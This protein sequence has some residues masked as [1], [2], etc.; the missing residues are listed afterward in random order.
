MTVERM[1]IA[2]I[3][4]LIALAGCQSDRLANSSPSA[5]DFSQN[6]Q[7]SPV[8]QVAL[9]SPD[10][11]LEIVVST[12]DGQP[13]YAVKKDDVE[14]VSPSKLG[15]RFATGADLDA[16]F[17]IASITAQT[18]VDET[19]EQ[20]W[21][22]KRLVH[23]R[24][25]E[26]AIDFRSTENPD[27]RFLLRVRAFDDGF[28][29]RYEVPDTGERA[30]IDEITE[31][32]I[33]PEA[34]AWWTPAGEFNRYEYIYRTTTVRA[35][36]R[37]HTPF[38]VRLPDS[39]THLAIHEA[40]LVD[41]AG[42]WLDQRR[43]GVLEADLAPR[44]DGVKVRVEGAFKSPWRAVQVSDSAAGLINGSDIYLNLNKPNALGDVSYFKPGKYI[45]IWWGMHI[46][47]F[48]WGSGPKHGAT[49]KRTK[50]YIDFAAEHGFGGVLV[51][52]WNLGW[53]GDWFHNGEVFNFTTPYPDFDL[54]AL[55]DYAA[56]K[57]VEIIGHHETSGNISNYENQLE[58]AF[59]LYADNG[60]STVKTG[61]VA[62][63]SDLKFYDEDGHARYTWHA[64]QERVAHDLHV[65][66]RAHEYGIAINAHEPVKDTG[67]RRTYPNAVSREGARGMEFNA[68]G[69]PPNPPEHQAILPFT[70]LLAGPFD[71]T[72]GVFDLTPNG[73]D[74]ENR[75]PTT[76]AKQL[77][78]YV[79]I[80]SPV[81]MAADLP[82]NYEKHP[83]AFQFIKDVPADWEHSIALDGEVGDFVVMARQRRGG[84]DWYVGALTDENARTISIP[85]SFLEEGRQYRAEI[86][87]DGI[88]ADWR[89]AP[90]EMI[91]E[92]LEASSQD[93]LSFP[94]ATSGG[95]AVRL[96]PINT[97]ETP[98]EPTKKAMPS[99]GVLLKYGDLS[100]EF[101]GPRDVK[102]WLPPGYNESDARYRVIYMHDG[103]NLFERGYSYTG[104]SW[105]MDAAMGDLIAA[106]KI[107]PAIIVAAG[108]TDERW[109]DYAPESF[110]A[111][112]PV[113]QRMLAF[114]DQ[115][116]APHSASYLKFLVEE[117]KQ[118]VDAR[119]RTRSGSADTAIMGASMGG[120]ISLYAAA[121]Y[122]NVFGSAAGLSTHWPL[123]DPNKSDRS[124]T[125]NA[126]TAALDASRLN[127]GEQRLWFDHGSENLD[128]Y[129][130]PFQTVMDAYFVERGFTEENYQSSLY[131]G[132]D[133]NERSWAERIKDP[134]IFLLGTQAGDNGTN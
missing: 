111:E 69:T 92:T 20:P 23:D 130:A 120:L 113:D 118:M 53:D 94:L 32:S 129:Y 31:F 107:D 84:D 65:L 124:T 112:L 103:Q 6:E 122:P 74:A 125:L 87:R 95:A 66:K 21:G 104:D 58:D 55:S 116:G 71:F 36:E 105:E 102:I 45:G 57:G 68:W 1:K 29:F 83:G 48:T 44:H 115:G 63:A 54:V 28:A 17:S 19:W 43:A 59:Q 47:R 134:L 97:A 62:D 4:M 79:T 11:R 89:A 98:P 73:L 131:I 49:T 41:Y 91:I 101:V 10:G 52:G 76:L 15:L 133:H 46:G 38:T 5:Q 85:L 64:S 39:D 42:M 78:Q 50:A 123:F 93:T 128:S 18:S 33:D 2:C 100:S 56:E 35:M 99:G 75:V 8:D 61:Y 51:E 16:G 24:H 37:A 86:Y 106:N 114:E 110:L 126:I 14:I 119:F 88:N 90:Y 27:N 40:A 77:A 117:L 26:I 96:V 13:K 60:V 72:P 3:F 67:L 81:Q 30:L 82:E 80:Y 34:T 127:P 9:A 22:E 12:P 109:Q 70:R 121:E 7:V 132:A 25:E 108:F